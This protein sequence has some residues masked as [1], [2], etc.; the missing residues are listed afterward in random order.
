MVIGFGSEEGRM[1]QERDADKRLHKSKMTLLNSIAESVKNDS[2]RK[3]LPET[4]SMVRYL[5][6]CPPRNILLFKF[7]IESYVNE[8]QRCG[9]VIEARLASL[10]VDD[11]NKGDYNSSRVKNYERFLKKII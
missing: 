2:I 8:M 1:K 9:A 5:K 11:L 6:D 4:D 10:A 7:S 3:K